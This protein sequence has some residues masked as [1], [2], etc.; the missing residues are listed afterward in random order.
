[1]DPLTAFVGLATEMTKLVTTIVASQPPGVQKQLWEWYVEDIAWW[2][3]VLKI[4][5]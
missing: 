2:R 4:G 5:Q 1:M 3:K